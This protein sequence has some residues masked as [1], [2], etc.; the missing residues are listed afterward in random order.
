MKFTEI[1]TLSKSDF[2]GIENIINKYI[3]NNIV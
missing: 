3:S 1:D 2:E